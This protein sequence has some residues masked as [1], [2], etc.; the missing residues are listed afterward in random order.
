MSMRVL[1]II[2]IIITCR[3]GRESGSGGG[4]AVEEGLTG[5]E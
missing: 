5:N 1:A 2:G 3:D 4:V